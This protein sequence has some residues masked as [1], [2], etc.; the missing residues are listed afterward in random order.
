MSDKL[1]GILD[2]P[3]LGEHAPLMESVPFL[4]PLVGLVPPVHPGRVGITG[5]P[6][7][8]WCHR[9][10]LIGLVSPAH[11]GRAGVTSSPGWGCCHWLTLVRLGLFRPLLIEL[12]SKNLRIIFVTINMVLP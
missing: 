6:W 12:Q 2:D 1:L 11:P 9:L 5:S 3:K 8:G 4:T 10:T 7:L